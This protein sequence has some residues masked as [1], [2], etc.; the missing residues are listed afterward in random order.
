MRH[1]SRS[2]ACILTLPLLGAFGI[3]SVVTAEAAVAA[4]STVPVSV[5]AE[6]GL[7]ALTSTVTPAPP[8]AAVAARSAAAAVLPVSVD[9]KKWAVTPGNQGSSNSCVAWVVDYAMLGWYGRYSGRVGQPFAPM[10]TY[11]QINGGVDNGSSPAAALRLGVA[12]GNDTRANYSPGD[13]NWKTQPTAA[14]RVSASRFKIRSFTTLFVGANRATNSTTLKQALA[15]NHPVAIEMSVRYGFDYLSKSPSAVDTDTTSA[16][17]GEHEVLAIG[18][19]ASGLI[20]QNSWGTGWANGGFGRISWAVV[21]K[22]VGEAETIEGFAQAA[23]APAAGV[24]NAGRAVVV[25]KGV[26]DK[27]NVTWHNTL[28]D[29]GAVTANSAWYQVDGGRWIMVKLASATSTSFALVARVGHH[30]RVAAR[31]AAGGHVGAVRYGT[32][33][34]G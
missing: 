9:L 22:D 6:H 32:T 17:R 2:A 24:P 25:V 20:V 3:G 28:G 10:Y 8:V 34:A 11:S 13:S 23:T 29:T 30:Y 15:S 19:D 5:A 26:T 4:P 7:G 16:V 12:Q 18:Y 31:A 27:Y 33:F 1:L 14:Q 21:Q